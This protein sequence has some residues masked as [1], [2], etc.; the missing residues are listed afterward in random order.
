V[1]VDADWLLL[2]EDKADNLFPVQIQISKKP[3][4]TVE[5]LMNKTSSSPFRYQAVAEHI[6]GLIT[7]GAFAPGD[8]LPSLRSLSTHMQVSISTVS[9]AYVKLEEQ[10]VITARPR[11][12]FFVARQTRKLPPFAGNPRP[13]LEP[14]TVKRSQLIRTVLEAVGD[15]SLVPFAII[16]PAKE[17]LP[18]RA[19]S[20][21]MRQVVARDD[22]TS[23]TY[24]PCEGDLRLRRQICFRSID[25][26]IS[27]LPQ[28]ILVTFGAMEALNIGLRTVT[29]PGDTVLVQSPTYFC[30]LQL[31]ENC[32]LRAI[33]IGSNP[34]TGVDPE[35]IAT[36]LDTF[37]IKAGILA[38][39]FNN[40]DGSL[41]PE[42]AKKAITRIFEKRD[43][44]L[45]EDDVSGELHFG[46]ARPG[47]YKQHDRNGNVIYCSSFSKTLAPGY[48]VGWMI[49][50]KLHDQ[51]LEIKAT[52]SVCSATPTQM[53]VAAYLESGQYDRHLR[54]LR[55]AIANQMKTLQMAITEHFPQG[56]RATRPQ[57]GAV[58]WVELPGDIDAVDYFFRAKKAGIGI[59]PGTIFSTQEN[60]NSFIRLSCDGIWNAA[61]QEGIAKL[62]SIAADMAGE[63]RGIAGRQG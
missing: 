34:R 24:A 26:G 40:P 31:L 42:P 10:G 18:H 62:G 20:T 27:V 48:R 2:R 60:Y 58:L 28:D 37:D 9:Q 1:F 49:P 12:G 46:D 55:Q 8:R 33:E 51:A 36:A 52:S 50:G 16:S 7:S 15:T 59:A 47:T 29:R 38:S 6:Q 43:I 22:G 23:L 21:F 4:I 35:D 32:G 11:S 39:N 54:K 61:M 25:A 30:F 13:A 53:V 17:L 14:T 44:P 45:I 56:T 3:T 57:G 5:N 19:L 63:K 41:T